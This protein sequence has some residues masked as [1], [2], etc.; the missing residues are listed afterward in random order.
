MLTETVQAYCNPDEFPIPDVDKWCLR[1]QVNGKENQ[2]QRTPQKKSHQKTYHHKRNPQT[3]IK[4]SKSILIY[5][6]NGN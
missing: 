3:I 6:K 4:Y 5:D 1:N 2:Q